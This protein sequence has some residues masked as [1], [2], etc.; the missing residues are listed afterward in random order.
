MMSVPLARLLRQ[1]STDTENKLWQL[2]RHRRLHGY[3]FRRQHPIGKFI[4]DFACI[5]YHLIVEADGSQHAENKYDTKRTKWLEN[6]GWRVI[7]FWNNEILTN[8]D[9]VLEI[10]LKELQERQTQ[11]L[12]RP[13]ILKRLT[14]T[15]S[16]DAGEGKK[17]RGPCGPRSV[18]NCL[19]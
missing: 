2:L 12:T 14:G 16:R 7:R 9:G 3:R 5:K 17:K 1:E 19:N 18:P 8:A 11:P 4:A 13:S 15:L 10:I 6:E